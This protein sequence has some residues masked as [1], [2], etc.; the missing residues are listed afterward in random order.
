LSFLLASSSEETNTKSVPLYGSAFQSDLTLSL[1][2]LSADRKTAVIYAG[3]VD[4]PIS[5]IGRCCF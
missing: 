2:G 3:I 4:E 5:G 1:P